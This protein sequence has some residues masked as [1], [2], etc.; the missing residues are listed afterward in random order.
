[1]IVKCFSTQAS[2]CKIKKL[3]LHCIYKDK[4]NVYISIYQL[5][6]YDFNC[7]IQ[8][9][10]KKLFYFP[11]SWKKWHIYNIYMNIQKKYQQQQNLIK[12]PLTSMWQIS[13]VIIS[14]PTIEQSSIHQWVSCQYSAQPNQFSTNLETNKFGKK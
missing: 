11:Y 4:L 5:L 10:R 1:M 2:K 9:I 12:K 8:V 6:I 3:L 7:Y 13:Y 14:C